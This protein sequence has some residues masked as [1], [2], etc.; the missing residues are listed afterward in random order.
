[1][2]IIVWNMSKIISLISGIKIYEDE[3]F[4]NMK[5]VILEYR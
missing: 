2:K 5:K 4:D 3:L 1:M